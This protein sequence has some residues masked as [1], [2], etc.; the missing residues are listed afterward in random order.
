MTNKSMHPIISFAITTVICL[1]VVA[2]AV[3]IL[4]KLAPQPTY[5]EWYHITWTKP[6]GTTQTFRGSSRS[7]QY[8]VSISDRSVTCRFYLEN[9]DYVNIGGGA[10][11]VEPEETKP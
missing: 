4:N 5:P 1:V 11:K 8:G 7:S 6:D 9:G 3:S 10:I 2:G